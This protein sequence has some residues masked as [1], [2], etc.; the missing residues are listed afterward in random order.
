MVLSRVLVI[1]AS[2]CLDTSHGAVDGRSTTL[3]YVGP[4][5]V[6]NLRCDVPNSRAVGDR[7]GW[8]RVG[9]PCA[10]AARESVRRSH[11]RGGGN[12]FQRNGLFALRGAHENVAKVQDEVRAPRALT[13]EERKV[14]L[15]Y[16][17]EEVWTIVEFSFLYVLQ[18]YI[19]VRSLARLLFV[20]VCVCVYGVCACTVCVWG[21]G[22]WQMVALHTAE[23]GTV[24]FKTLSKLG[25]DKRK[26]PRKMRIIEENISQ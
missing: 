11:L 15:E 8:R 26:N 19:A 6:Q 14:A 3:A 7:E 17:T 5:T 22:G 4:P 2:M 21:G 10:L 24:D 25:K 9:M 16:I 18:Q 20:C 23:D 13:A 1:M 12:R